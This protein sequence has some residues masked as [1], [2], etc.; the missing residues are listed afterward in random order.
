MWKVFPQVD[1]KKLLLGLARCF[2]RLIKTVHR[3]KGEVQI[4]KMEVEFVNA[5]TAGGRIK[6]LP[7]V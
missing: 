1:L 6:F 2:L 7:A 3:T 4:I 5:V